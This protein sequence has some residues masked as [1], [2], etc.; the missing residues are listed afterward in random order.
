MWAREAERG[1][2]EGLKDRPAVVV[3]ARIVRETQ[4]EITVAPVTHSMPND[5]QAAVEIPAKVKRQ[6]GLDQ[7]RSWIVTSELNRFV[8]PGP[9]IRVAPGRD[10]P[11]YDAIPE[12][13]FEKLRVAVNRQ[14]AAGR[15]K[16]TKRTE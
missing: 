5:P 11:V 7:E 8:W 12:L 1:Q 13:L 14:V 16:V 2:D 3:I 10:T 15:L 6:L 4:T 9:D